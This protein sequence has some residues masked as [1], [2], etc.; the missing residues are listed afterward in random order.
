MIC[1]GTK[2]RTRR[3]HLTTL[4]C[5]AGAGRDKHEYARLVVRQLRAL[6]VKLLPSVR[7][8]GTVFAVKKM[9][10]C[11][12]AACMCVVVVGWAPAVC[13]AGAQP[14][15]WLLLLLVHRQESPTE[16]S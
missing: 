7:G 16:L 12:N 2:R 6:K 1:P 9:L 11:G 13:T 4:S 8:G 10:G 14:G 15:C 3:D 5:W